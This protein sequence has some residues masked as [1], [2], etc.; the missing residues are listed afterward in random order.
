[1][2]GQTSDLYHGEGALR[3][4]S[5]AIE[6]LFSTIPRSFPACFRWD[7]GPLMS[8]STAGKCVVCFIPSFLLY[9]PFVERIAPVVRRREPHSIDIPSSFLKRLNI[10]TF[11]DASQQCHPIQSSPIVR[12]HISS[13][14]FPCNP[15]GSS[16][17]SRHVQH[18]LARFPIFFT[19][20]KL[21][22]SR[23]IKP[24]KKPAGL[25]QAPKA[26][27]PATACCRLCFSISP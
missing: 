20:D 3:A 27:Q 9:S 22:L 8:T 13:T 12:E 16:L 4:T 10:P 18:A 17:R 2:I 26:L 7:M 14:R 15:P 5:P 19:S 21:V 23:P 1:M 25:V 11:H 6:Q 24:E